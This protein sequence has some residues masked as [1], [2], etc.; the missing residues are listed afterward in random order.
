MPK[1]TGAGV[2]IAAFSLFFGFAMI[3]HIWWLAIIGFAGMIVTWIVHSFNE[4]VDYYVPVSE[5][6]R[7]ENRHFEQISEAGVNNVN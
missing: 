2:V 5:V 3:W 6:E 7:I 1:N 4:D